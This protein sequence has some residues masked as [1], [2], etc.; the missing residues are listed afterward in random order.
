MR[1]RFWRASDGAAVGNL[2]LEPGQTPVGVSPKG[3]Y[4]LIGD[5]RG[6]TLS[7]V[8]TV[9]GRRLV[10]LPGVA[11]E[12]DLVVRAARLLAR[13]SGHGGPGVAIEVTKRLP[14]GGG[15]GGGSSD[16]ATVLVDEIETAIGHQLAA[17]HI[18]V[19]EIA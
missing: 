17:L 16:A 5:E 4:A 12:D 14:M 11:A 6:R 18:A 1:C 3:S 2:L 15:V 8:S 9:D 10:E 7:L 13:E 19:R